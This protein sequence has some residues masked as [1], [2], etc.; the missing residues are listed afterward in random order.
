MEHTQEALKEIVTKRCQGN[1]RDIIL[2]LFKGKLHDGI[3]VIIA[4]LLDLQPKIKD[5]VILMA[6]CSY[7][8]IMT[9]ASFSKLDEILDAT[10]SLPEMESALRDPDISEIVQWNYN[11]LS[12]RSPVLG[13]YFLKKDQVTNRLF[14]LAEEIIKN[15]ITYFSDEKDLVDVAKRLLRVKSYQFAYQDI[16]DGDQKRDVFSRIDRIHDTAKGVNFANKDPLFWVQRS[17]CQLHLADFDA[18]FQFTKNAY[19]AANS[20]HG[21]DTY[22]ID[23]HYATLLLE[24]SRFHNLDNELRREQK[25]WFLLKGV[26][27]RNK[28]SLY[29]PIS[30]C[31]VFESLVSKYEREIKS[32][33]FMRN[34]MMEILKEIQEIIRS[35]QSID[36]F[37]SVRQVSDGIR[38]AL[39]RLNQ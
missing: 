8:N 16:D 7:A 1:I 34:V 27:T 35:R 29:H 24:Y 17:I 31:R 23:T 11:N 12:F 9:D 10:V 33:S 20:R 15:I 2:Y 13:E 6:F 19:G 28:E 5:M 4:K 22:Q 36:R 30:A 32:D 39:R 25:A 26:L 38:S 37:P 3:D 14:D 18:A 21:F